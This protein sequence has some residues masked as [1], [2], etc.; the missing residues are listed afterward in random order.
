MDRRSLLKAT[1]IAAA[2]TTVGVT[3]SAGIASGEVEV[4]QESDYE[5]WTVTGKEVYDLSD[6]EELSNVLVDQSAD[7]ACLTIRSRNSRNWEVRNVGFVGVGQAGSGSNRFQ[8]QVSAPEGSQGV[9]ENVWANG[10]ERDGQPSTELGGIYIR[11]AHG[12]QMKI[13]NTYIEGYGN[14]GA[15]ASA[16]GKDS[17]NG[18]TV[19]IENAYH[20]DNTVSQFRIGSTDSDVRNCVGIVNDPNGERGVYTGTTDNRNARGI[21]GLHYPDQRV[22]NSSF[23]VS[24]DD[25]NPDGVFE[26][27][28]IPGRSGG[29][30]AVL[31]VVDCDVNPDAPSL[32]ESTSNAEV[33]FT[34]LGNE[35]TAD[36]IGGGGVPL[37]PEMAARGER[38]MPDPPEFSESNGGDGT[39]DLDRTLTIDG[40]NADRT[41]YEFTVSGEI[42]ENPDVGSLGE[43][44]QIDGATAT[45]FVN[46]GVD[47]YLFSGEIT[48]AT[49]DGNA[50]ILV[51]GEEVDFGTPDLDRT[52]TFDGTNA[53]RTDYQFTVSGE[54][55]ENP[56]VGSLG[57][58][59]QIDGSTATGFVNGGIDGYLFSGEITD[60][61]VDGNATVLLDGEEVD[62]ET[63]GLNRTLTVDGTDAERTDYEFT[64]SGGLAENPDV[65]SL[66]EGDQIDG[67]TATGFV[68]GGIDGYLF[69]GEVTDAS[70]TGDAPILVDGEPLDLGQ[71]ESAPTIDRY[72]VVEVDSPNPDANIVVEWDVSDPDGDLA[73]ATVEVVNDS[74]TVV[75]SAE[76]SISG[77]VA[78]GVDYF[79]IEDVDGQ[80]FSVQLTVTDSSGNESSASESVQE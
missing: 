22:E 23:Y 16:M 17:G 74:G 34:N 75:D 80:R 32:R 27:R 62:P 25:V 11:A 77:D 57:E 55:A 60:A 63:L 73:S 69:S 71:F 41:D 43:G 67:S 35:P 68:N 18:G 15:Y 7:G 4:T 70:V 26:A 14:N 52:L 3:S 5:V 21:W 30:R 61:T 19:T 56:D 50:T 38:E 36:V 39:P 54:I 53:D 1:G 79:A 51:D 8:F 44:D 59:D 31:E 13:R 47:G 2:T 33:N 20:R 65:G 42:A 46:G 76:T 37:S 12:G 64:V 49:V 24:P 78:Y 66:G 48:D 10:K 29:S 9:I 6:G 40:T 45:G 72:E 28:Y 58:G